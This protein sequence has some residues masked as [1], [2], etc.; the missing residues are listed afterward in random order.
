MYDEGVAAPTESRILN[1]ITQTREKLGGLSRSTIYE[2]IS[3]GDLR[4]VKI[5]RR[6]FIPEESLRT[7][8]EK[9]GA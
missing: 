4:V 1:S 2:L 9:M 7:F 6:S 3:R 8:V 5:G